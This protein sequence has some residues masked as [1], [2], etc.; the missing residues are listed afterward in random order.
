MLWFTAEGNRHYCSQRTGKAGARSIM[1][2]IN[3]LV[4]QLS[5]SAF[6]FS[7]GLLCDSV[8]GAIPCIEWPTRVGQAY[9][10]SDANAYAHF[11][12][13]HEHTHSEYDEY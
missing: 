9:H 11:N 5:Q 2:V 10:H 4:Q 13:Q 3:T 12:T 1:W 6:D 8:S 7:S